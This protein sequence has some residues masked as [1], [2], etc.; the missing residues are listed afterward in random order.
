MILSS[1][2]SCW[3]FYPDGEKRE[4]QSSVKRSRQPSL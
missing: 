4:N 2:F 1:S 3:Q